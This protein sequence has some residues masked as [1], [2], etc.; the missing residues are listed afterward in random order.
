[1]LEWIVSSAA[2]CALIIGLRYLLR[3]RIGLRLQYALW[4]LVLLRLLLPVSFGS[5]RFS[6]MNALPEEGE[7]LPPVSAADS[8]TEAEGISPL[9]AAAPL[10]ISP[11]SLA[12]A[13]RTEARPTPLVPKTELPAAEPEKTPLDAGRILRILWLAGTGAMLLWFAGVNLRFAGRLRRS[14]ERFSGEEDYPLPVYVTGA[15][16][17]PCLFGLFRP[18]VYLPP[19]AAADPALGHILAHE[20]THFRHGDQAWSLLRSL[21]LAIHWFDPL[22]WWAAFLSRRDGELACDEGTLR[23]LGDGERS[24]YGRTLLR[25]TCASR[26]ALFRAA[27]TMTGSKRGLKERIRLIVRKPRT[28]ILTLAAVIMTAALALGCTFTG[29]KKPVEYNDEWF[30]ETAWPYAEEY[31]KANAL[32]ITRENYQVLH[33]KTQEAEVYFPAENAEEVLAVAFSQSED[34]TWAALKGNPV[35]DIPR[36]RGFIMEAEVP[37]WTGQKVSTALSYVAGLVSD[38]NDGYPPWSGGKYTANVNRITKVRLTGLTSMGAGTQGLTEGQELLRLEYRLLPEDQA[39]IDLPEGMRTEV[40][41]GE[42]WITEWSADGQPYLLLRWMVPEGDPEQEDLWF[43]AGVTHTRQLEEVYGTPEMLEKYG[44]RYTAA[45]AELYAAYLAGENAPSV[46]LNREDFTLVYPGDSFQM[47]VEIPPA[48]RN[49]TVSWFSKDPN[50]ATVSKD[51]LVTAVDHGTTKIEVW[52]GMTRAQCT[53]RVSGYAS[54]SPEPAGTPPRREVR[55]SFEPRDVP[56]GIR[57]MAK[58]HV[59]TLIEAWNDGVPNGDG[60]VTANANPIVSA[61]ITGVTPVWNGTGDGGERRAL[62]LLEYRLLPEDQE[63]IVFTEGMRAEFTDGQTW[64]TEWGEN[65]QPYLLFFH[66]GPDGD[67]EDV[68]G[69]VIACLTSARELAEYDTPEMRKKY[70]DAYTAAAAELYAAKSMEV[71]G[72]AI[73]LQWI[74]VTLRVGESVLPLAGVDPSLSGERITWISGDPAVATVS[75]DGLVTAVDQGVTKII[76]SVGGYTAECT[77]RVHGVA[78]EPEQSGYDVLAEGQLR[79]VEEKEPVVWMPIENLDMVEGHSYPQ[80]VEVSSTLQGEPITWISED[81]DVAEV[82]EKGVITAV[83]PGTTKVTITVGEYS[84]ECTV[85]VEKYP[86]DPAAESGITLDRSVISLFAGTQYLLTSDLAPE[87][88]GAEVVWSSGDPEIASVS[89]E[90]LVTA[91]GWGTTRVYAAAG[92]RMTDCVVMVTG[93]ARRGGEEDGYPVNERGETY[94]G[95]KDLNG[96]T[97]EPDLEAA[98]GF[99]PEGEEI[100]GYVRTFD[101]YNGGPVQHPRSPAEA[102][103]YNAAM[104]ELRWEALDE[105]RDYLYSLPLYDKDGETVIGYFPVGRP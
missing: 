71:R 61:R 27:T 33:M 48:L 38:W 11:G 82:D 92:D 89:P 104:E 5:S 63:H 26:P 36:E 66:L 52:V 39:H 94:G 100:D 44:D 8:R 14:R 31:A 57:E 40:I 53:V 25:M 67:V 88:S 28:A 34:G 35:R 4:G 80:I 21:A 32:S 17:T 41:D 1:M 78:P 90:G 74:D 73:S 75:Q 79:W 56:E 69:S 15:A 84:A 83:N 65:G 96:V 93:Y 99:T 50:V 23:R 19:E 43:L 54:G 85:R 60:T 59:L 95:I 105:G 10:P 2:L 29:A 68:D 62:Y 42:T 45:A 102:L 12:P 18:A 20:L 46:R 7:L 51:G 91:V 101:L 77:I 30:A 55:I 87:L 9:P 98:A 72:R 37:D 3:G 97:L 58:L 16:E 70:G 64:I 103:A 81:P 86:P 6:I 47:T 22:V 13:P 49:A 24:A 76:A